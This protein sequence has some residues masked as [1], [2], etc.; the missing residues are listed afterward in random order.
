[1]LRSYP[2]IEYGFVK[3]AEGNA[4]LRQMVAAVHNKFAGTT[5]GRITS[6]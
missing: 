1:M 2:Q 5:I 6:A 4:E 3:H